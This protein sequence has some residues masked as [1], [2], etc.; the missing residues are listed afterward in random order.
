MGDDFGGGDFGDFGNGDDGDD[1][2]PDDQGPDDQNDDDQQGDDQG[3]DDQNDPDQ[4][5]GG[6]D[7]N[8]DDMFASRMRSSGRSGPD[9]PRAFRKTSWPPPTRSLLQYCSE[10]Q[11]NRHALASV[12]AERIGQFLADSQLVAVHVGHPRRNRRVSDQ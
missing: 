9:R 8:L 10:N 11:L 6:D 5:D 12:K 7:D 3:G 1:G 4:R 2:A